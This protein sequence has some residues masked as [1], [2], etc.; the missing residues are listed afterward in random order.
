MSSDKLV[1]IA[2]ST[3]ELP[4]QCDEKWMWLHLFRGK[5]CVLI[6]TSHEIIAISRPGID[7]DVIALESYVDFYEH[8]FVEDTVTKVCNAQRIKV[9]LEERCR[10]AMIEVLADRVS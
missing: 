10:E 2:T 5:V 7:S 9:L 3:V 1:H 6:N 8:N 4:N